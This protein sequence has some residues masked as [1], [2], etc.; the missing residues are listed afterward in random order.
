MVD[1]ETLVKACRSVV[2]RA[3][4]QRER[5]KYGLSGGPSRWHLDLWPHMDPVTLWKEGMESNYALFTD[6]VLSVLRSRLASVES[7]CAGGSLDQLHIFAYAIFDSYCIELEKLRDVEP[8]A[9]DEARLMDLCAYCW[10]EMMK[11]VVRGGDIGGA[12][13]ILAEHKGIVGYDY[14][15]I[16]ALLN[17]GV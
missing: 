2:P 5:E 13:R 4:L 11:V 10:D 16:K 3:L 9:R 1:P 7:L 6:R 8:F 15:K 14:D 17:E 12:R